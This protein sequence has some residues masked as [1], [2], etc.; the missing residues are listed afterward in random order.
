MT[1]SEPQAQNFFGPDGPI[2]RRLPDFEA[3]PQQIELAAAVDEALTNRRHLVA[4]AGTGTGKSFAYL[5]PAAVHAEKRQGEGPIIISTRTIALQEQLE[6]KD[7]P[8]LHAVLPMEWSSVTAIGRNNYLCLRRMHLAMREQGMFEGPERQEHLQRIVDWSTRAVDG[9]RQELETPPLP[10]VWEEVQAEHGNCLHRACKHYDRCYWQRSRRRMQTAQVLI[11]NHSLYFADLALRI[12]GASFL[13]PH[14]VVIFDEAHHLERTA[15]ESLGLRL[16]HSTVLWHLRRLHKRRSDRSLL[17]QNGSP[18]A[19]VF[20]EEARQISEAFFDE[21]DSRLRNNDDD[22]GGLALHDEQI[23]E[24]LSHIL[25]Q[26]AQEVAT[27]A[28]RTDEVELRMELQARAKG[29]DSLCATVRALCRPTEIETPLVR[30]LEPGRRGPQL[31]AAPL[32]VSSALREHLFE[33]GPTS[34]LLS[35]TVGT[36]DDPEF[37][38]FRRKLGL[39]DARTSKSRCPIR[40]ARATRSASRW[41]TARCDT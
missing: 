13:P 18:A 24:P 39:D 31:C 22:R 14:R 26:L 36:G 28:G 3:R 23:D 9:T 35:A 29:L 2:A 21:L 32:D 8:F 27:A 40:A 41:P 33:N 11:V 30:W 20:W 16:S 15:T 19:R 4:E 34:V 7:L 38:W 17:A 1:D 5:V 12:A 6:H 10:E 25:G 37:T